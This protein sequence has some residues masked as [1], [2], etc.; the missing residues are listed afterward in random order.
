MLYLLDYGAGNVASLG[1][2][3][4]SSSSSSQHLS[5]THLACLQP[6]RSERL[7]TTSNGFRRQK[8]SKRPM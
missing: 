6:T 1:S 8:T 5:L 7:A 2:S 4:C 3:V